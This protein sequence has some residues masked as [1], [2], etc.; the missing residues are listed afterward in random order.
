MA[1]GMTWR[2][3]WLSLVDASLNSAASGLTVVVV[4]PADF[5]PTAEGGLGR[6][7]TVMAVSA[8]FGAATWLKGHRLPGVEDDHQP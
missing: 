3:F 4:D 7:A 5:S 2:R 8:A 1:H 6:L